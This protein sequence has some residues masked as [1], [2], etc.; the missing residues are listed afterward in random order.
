MKKT[1][2]ICYK[3]LLTMIAVL[4]AVSILSA[5]DFF[6]GSPTVIELP[7]AERPV[8][9]PSRRRANPSQSESANSD[10]YGETEEQSETYPKVAFIPQT[11]DDPSQNLIWQELFRLALGFDIEISLYDG[12]N[13]PEAQFRAITTAIAGGYDFILLNPIH[14]ESALPA[15][16]RAVEEGI[17]VGMFLN[18]LPRADQ[19]LRSFYIGFDDFMGAQQAGLFVAENFQSGAGFVEIGGLQDSRE[20]LDRHDG[21]RAGIYGADPPIEEIASRN[22]PIGWSEHEAL[23]IIRDF[24]TRYRA[25]IDIVFC[26]WDVAAMAVMETFQIYG[27]SDVYVIGFGGFGEL[28]PTL[29]GEN[30]IAITKNYSKIAALAIE[31]INTILQGGTPPPQ[32][33]VPMEIIRFETYENTEPE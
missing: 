5:C 31:H 7:A 19:R 23:A 16:R 3:I 9:N 25:S 14:P 2:S 30:T 1:N 6:G 13:N 8:P 17:A 10:E 22:T 27:I 15:I 24:I 20:Q 21:F 29:L 12:Q 26:Q 18:D 11:I 28:D 33:I 32:T 4:F